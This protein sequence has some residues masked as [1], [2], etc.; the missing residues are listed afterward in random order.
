M[1][2]VLAVAF[3]TALVAFGCSASDEGTNG[4]GAGGPTPPGTPD[5]S[6]TTTP[7]EVPPTEPSVLREL[8]TWVEGSPN[9]A[10]VPVARRLMEEIA[11]PFAGFPQSARGAL[12]TGLNWLHTAAI[13]G[14]EERSRSRFVPSRSEGISIKPISPGR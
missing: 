10:E 4:P 13:R 2:R 3:A 6:V 5:P 12:E 14:A 1:S 8:H 11:D 9:P 7:S